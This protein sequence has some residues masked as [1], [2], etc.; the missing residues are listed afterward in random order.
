MA[1]SNLRRSINIY[2]NGL[3]LFSAFWHRPLAMVILLLTVAMV[4]Y[5]F[6][7]AFLQKRKGRANNG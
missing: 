4:A 3:D 2:G 7:A 6:I 1:E 5:P